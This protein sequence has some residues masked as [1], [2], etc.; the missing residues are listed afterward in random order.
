MLEGVL[1]DLLK[2]KWNTFVKAK[3]YRQFYIFTCYFLISLAAFC[4]RP[5][6]YHEDDDADDNK[7]STAM[8]LSNETLN[9]PVKSFIIKNLTEI[10]CN[11]T[12][13]NEAMTILTNATN[14]V[15]DNETISI[16]DEVE[17]DQ[18]TAFS[19]C[20]LLDISTTT[21]R[22]KLAAEGMLTVFAL[23]Y[24]LTAFRELRFL[25]AKM[26]FE[27]LV[28][29]QTQ[30]SHRSF[31]NVTMTVHCSLAQCPISSY[32]RCRALHH[33]VSCFCSLAG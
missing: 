25:G 6:A 23:Y 9:A 24:I 29:Q 31:V 11:Y 3:F 21:L 1:I 14:G 28:S 18:W 10:I 17:T 4:L 12:V 22:V 8:G 5:K 7:N 2:T 26:F 20:P 33:H 27:N 13:M 32:N 19:E 16:E 30:R 15:H